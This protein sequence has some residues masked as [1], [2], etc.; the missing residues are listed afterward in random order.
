MSFPSK[1]F[2]LPT[3]HLLVTAIACLLLGC[4][5]RAQLGTITEGCIQVNEVSFVY[6][7][8]DG[9]LKISGDGASLC[10]DQVESELCSDCWI[11]G[12]VSIHFD[13]NGNGVQDLGD[14]VFDITVNDSGPGN[15]TCIDLTNIQVNG[16]NSATQVIVQYDLTDCNGR[17]IKKRKIGRG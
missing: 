13:I 7:V 8:E 6:S 17:K 1:L 10:V 16:I 2:G 11:R 9:E 14:E 3:C 15:T 5:G 4:T 12:S